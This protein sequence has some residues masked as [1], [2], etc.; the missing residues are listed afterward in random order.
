[1]H[2][3]AANSR[4]NRLPLAIVDQNDIDDVQSALGKIDFSGYAR[5]S[6]NVTGGTKLMAIACFQLF[7]ERD[8]TRVYYQPVDKPMEML[9]PRHDA[10]EI[11]EQLSIAEYF[12]SCGIKICNNRCGCDYVKDWEHNKEILPTMEYGIEVRNLLTRLQNVPWV[13]NQLKN[14]GYI[15][16]DNMSGKVPQ[17]MRE[18]L[19]V[20]NMAKVALSLGF[21][22][23]KLTS[24][25]VKYIT[26]GWF[27][28]YVCQKRIAE[29]GFK[30]GEQIALGVNIETSSGVRNEFD[31]VY[32]D[33]NELHIIECKST[34]DDK[35]QTETLYKIQALKKDFGLTVRSHLYTMSVI[36]KESVQKRAKDFD[37][38]IVDRASL[39]PQTAPQGKSK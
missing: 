4:F 28:E 31:V 27:E 15:D 18:P 37:I 1:M 9:H 32:I 25:E 10:I 17:E 38:D 11:G 2:S 33:K 6:V 34:L 35:I 14:K 20:G 21:N 13:N 39:A 7:T 19:A 29:E 24:R 16:L 3:N 12:A 22:P 26:G 23:N 36:D 8:N 30:P 5:V